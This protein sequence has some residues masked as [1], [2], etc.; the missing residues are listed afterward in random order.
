MQY[1][2]RLRVPRNAVMR[3]KNGFIE[4]SFNKTGLEYAAYVAKLPLI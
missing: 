3:Q 4:A 1:T 2:A